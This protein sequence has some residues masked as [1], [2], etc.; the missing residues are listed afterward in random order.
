LLSSLPC[1]DSK[2]TIFSSRVNTLVFLMAS[3]RPAIPSFDRPLIGTPC[4]IGDEVVICRA[5]IALF[6]REGVTRPSSFLLCGF[7]KIRLTARTDKLKAGAAPKQES[8]TA[9]SHPSLNVI[10][11]PWIFGG[12]QTNFPFLAPKKGRNKAAPANATD[13]RRAFFFSIHLI[14]FY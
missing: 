14:L 7:L 12:L 3:D 5:D 6:I 9:C 2:V 10:T 11:Q 1:P 13:H 4:S 8:T